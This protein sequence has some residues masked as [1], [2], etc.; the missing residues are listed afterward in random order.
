VTE[1]PVVRLERLAERHLADL[2]ALVRDPDVLRF[3]RVPDPPPDGF[4]ELWLGRYL[5]GE[6][7]GSCAGFAALGA[8][9][10]FVGVGVAPTINPDGR[11]LE[12]G[13]VIAPDARGRGY[14]GALLQALTTWAFVEAQA[15]RIHLVVDVENVASL[16]VAERAGY[17]RE[18]TLR[19][20][21]VKQDRRADTA[22]FSLL[23][24]D[25]RPR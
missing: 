7:D 22:I 6:R 3:T 2:E 20:A 13:Y 4:G 10:A 1:R 15:L 18:G 24:D 9:D 8:D 19:S 23:A 25:P 5:D 14:A 16:R 12:L 17:V 21:W 11:E